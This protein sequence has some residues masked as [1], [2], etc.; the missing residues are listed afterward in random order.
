MRLTSAEFGGVPP[1]LGAYMLMPRRI[2]A[3]YLQAVPHSSVTQSRA[4]VTCTASAPLPNTSSN[5]WFCASAPQHQRT[6]FDRAVH[7]LHVGQ[8][9]R[10]G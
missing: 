4:T 5:T 7:M 6:W 2:T 8:V 1:D 9:S 3:M 10:S